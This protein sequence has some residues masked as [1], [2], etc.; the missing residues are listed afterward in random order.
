MFRPEYFRPKSLTRP[1]PASRF[2]LD[3]QQGIYTLDRKVTRYWHLSGN[4]AIPVA[5]ADGAAPEIIKQYSATGGK[6]VFFVVERVGLMPLVPGKEVGDSNQVYLRGEVWVDA[7]ATGLDGSQYAYHV[8]G[9]YLYVFKKPVWVDG[10]GLPLSSKVTDR[11]DPK[12]NLLPAAA[13]IDLT[14]VKGAYAAPGDRVALAA[15][16]AP[17]RLPAGVT[18]PKNSVYDPTKKMLPVI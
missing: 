3:A 15:S 11:S 16:L 4:L 7:P 5:A 12:L 18:G 1:I 9:Y 2:T 14:S 8:E 10:Q 17:S 6:V 13:F